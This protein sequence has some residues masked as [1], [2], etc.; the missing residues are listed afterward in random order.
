M[1]RKVC[2]VITARPSYS[3]IRSTLF[4]LRSD[5]RVH[6]DVV[7]AGSAILERF[8]GAHSVIAA[9]GFEPSAEVSMIFEGDRPAEMARSTG[10]GV[11][12]LAGVFERLKPDVVVTIA[13][14][15]ET[16]ATAIAAS[17]MGVPLAHIQGGEVTGNIDEKVR[18]A[19]TK[20][21]DIHLV[22]TSEA[23][24]RVVALGERPETVFLTGCPSID[25]AAE[26]VDESREESIKQMALTG[27]GS[28][29]DLRE[30]YLVVLQHPV[31]S[32]VGD[33]GRQI[34]ETLEAVSS[35]GIPTLW[36][37]P[38]VDAGSDLTSKSIRSFREHRGSA[39]FRFIK[40]VPPLAFLRLARHSAC[41][42]GNS[43]VGVREAGFLGTPVVNIGT[44]QSGRERCENVRDVGYHRDEIA[45]AIR[46]Q[47]AHG[48]FTSNPLYGDGK[49]AVRIA[50]ILATAPL[51]SDKKLTY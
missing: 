36:F 43:S 31:T 48:R 12:E 6:L 13:D 30:K 37:W 28:E 39:N 17:Y 38:N 51:T 50:E 27:V 49:A 4:R 47:I 35:L 14:R 21:S 19:V 1:K 9:D 26:V 44:R 22:A 23:Y 3:R 7:V 18:H 24:R 34:R 20:L 29:I 33:A 40:N 32:E 15:Y 42:I 16:M 25:I 10:V 46:D 2:V 8:G 11:L 45:A 5:E 41:L